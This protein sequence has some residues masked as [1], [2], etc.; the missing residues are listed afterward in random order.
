MAK[1]MRSVEAARPTLRRQSPPAMAECD[2]PLNTWHKQFHLRSGGPY[3]LI[4]VWSHS[5]AS[6]Q[7][8]Y[9]DRIMSKFWATLVVITL[10]V[11]FA[12]PQSV[13]ARTSPRAQACRTITNDQVG[14]LFDRWNKS[15]ATK[16]LPTVQNGPLVGPEAIRG[17]FIYFLKQAPEGQIDQRIIHIGCNIAYDIGLYTFTIDGDQPGTRK[18]VKARY[19]FIYAPEHGK[20]LIV[21]HH[22]SAT[23]KP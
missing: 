1:G 12:A 9:G 6:E 20:W 23:P 10:T 22:S 17:Y 11:V 19:T 7:S 18:Q 14:A 16:L 3:S 15:L 8:R 2:K 4:A 13:T 21:H 5:E